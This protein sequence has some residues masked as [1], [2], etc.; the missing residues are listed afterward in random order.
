MSDTDLSAAALAR[1]SPDRLVDLLD[2]VTPDHPGLAD[3]DI[4]TIGEV[5]DPK[6]LG[7]DQFVRLLAILDRLAGL[8]AKVDLSRMDARTFA[9]LITRASTDQV[10]GILARPELR[11]RVLNEIFRRMGDHLRADR[12]AHTRAVVHW[13]LTGGTGDGGYDRYETV[14]ENGVCELHHEST[15]DPR[16][17]I[18]V[19]PV[20]FLRLITNNASGP[21]LFM[22]GKLKIKGDLGF[23]A[24]LTSLFDIPSA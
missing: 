15:R 1:L 11:T 12:A 24:G 17:T 18:T 9:R 10:K 21:V 16:V 20:D 2:G 3:L 8:G 5:V 7:R 23:A 22:T 13:R 19:H 4:N 6:K 14:I